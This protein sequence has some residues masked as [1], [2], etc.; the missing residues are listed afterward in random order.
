MQI[1]LLE[2]GIMKKMEFIVGNSSRDVFREYTKLNKLI[3]ID[4]VK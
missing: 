3:P 4:N 2:V 1:N